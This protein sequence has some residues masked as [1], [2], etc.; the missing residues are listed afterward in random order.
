MPAPLNKQ[1]FSSVKIGNE[2]LDVTGRKKNYQGYILLCIHNHPNSDVLGY[3][4]EHRVVT[5]MC[6]GRYLSED[7][8]VHHKNEV[9][10]DN[11]F[12]NLEI[13][14]RG[15]HTTLHHLGST[16][17]DETKKRMSKAAKEKYKDKKNHPMY[18]DVD[19]ELVR[20]FKNGDKPIDIYTALG[21]SRKTYYN[22]IN[23][24]E[25]ER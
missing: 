22:K 9:K 19:D 16:R 17:G 14:K 21:I 23:Y 1:Y 4:L 5:E 6:H 24:L 2:I 11:R 18:R 10:H 7:E 20:M 12:S 8:I 3:V 25:L 15:E 13:L